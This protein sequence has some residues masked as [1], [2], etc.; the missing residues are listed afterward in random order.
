M[1]KPKSKFVRSMIRGKS[2][3][4]KQFVAYLETLVRLEHLAQC[5]T[6]GVGSY[7]VY[8][9]SDAHKREYKAILKELNPKKYDEY[10]KKL[11]DEKI[12]VKRLKIQFE[13]ERN[14]QVEED[15][16]VWLE[17]GGTP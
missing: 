15:K 8:G 4:D 9:L 2:F 5:G 6:W 7:I 16:R 14:A 13:K 10:L 3:R 1:K 11:E 12:Y 17:L